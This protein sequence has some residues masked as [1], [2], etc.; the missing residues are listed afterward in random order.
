[1]HF[2]LFSCNF[3]MS[4]FIRSEDL[5]IVGATMFMGDLGGKGPGF[6]AYRFLQ[7][8][9]PEVN[10]CQHF[11]PDTEIRNGRVFCPQDADLNEEVRN[12]VSSASLVNAGPWMLIT[13][14][15]NVLYCTM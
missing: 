3:R 13:M 6:T 14:L 15:A 1:M 8:A 12:E 2:Y 7:F 4:E 9:T 11:F 5:E 10:V